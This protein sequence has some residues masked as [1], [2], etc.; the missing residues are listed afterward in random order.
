MLIESDSGRV[1]SDTERMRSDSVDVRSVTL[2]M[3]SISGDVRR[4]KIEPGSVSGPVRSDSGRVRNTYGP[5]RSAT[6]EARSAKIEVRRG[7]MSEPRGSLRRV[8]LT[9][10][11]LRCLWHERMLAPGGN[12]VANEVEQKKN[13]TATAPG[14][15]LSFL[16]F[17][18]S[19]LW[20]SC[21][22]RA[23]IS[24]R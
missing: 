8:K 11:T 13:S 23:C 18:K 1:R 5:F 16:C 6:G 19:T 2:F 7:K 9:K 4:G 10:R 12:I 3:R 24:K 22:H 14:H 15:F 21:K 17:A 20:P